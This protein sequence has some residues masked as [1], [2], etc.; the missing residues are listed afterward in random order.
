MD[1]NYYQKQAWTTA[2]Y[3]NA[4]TDLT[5]PTLGL[6]G[7]CGEVAEKVKKIIRDK[8]GVVNERDKEE[9]AK[10]ISDCYWYLGALCTT[11]GL[12]M[13]DVAQLNLDKLFSRK[14]RGVLGGS[15]DNR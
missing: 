4:G 7:E 11:L 5:Y 10:E 14:E 9:L 2:I 13:N 3:P 15:G 1:F 6:C 8:N 12:N